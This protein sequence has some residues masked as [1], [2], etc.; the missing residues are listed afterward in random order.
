MMAGM[1]YLHDYCDD[2]DRVCRAIEQDI[3]QKVR[4]LSKAKGRYYRGIHADATEQVYGKGFRHFIA[5]RRDVCGEWSEWPDEWPW[6]VDARVTAGQSAA[7]G[8]DG[9]GA[10]REGNGEAQAAPP[11]GGA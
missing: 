11:T 5:V 1:R 7:A 10:K 2:F 3:A 8:A 4:E 9:D 6:L